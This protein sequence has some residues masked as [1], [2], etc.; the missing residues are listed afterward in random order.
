MHSSS[1]SRRPGAFSPS[2][3][4]LEAREVPAAIGALDPTF[5]TAGKLIQAGTAFQAAVF[6]FHPARERIE[7]APRARHHRF[8]MHRRADRNAR[9]AA[10]LTNGRNGRT[11]H[12]LCRLRSRDGR[13][14]RGGIHE[15]Q[16]R[17]N[18][19]LRRG[20]YQAGIAPGGLGQHAVQVGHRIAGADCTRARSQVLA[21]LRRQRQTREVILQR[22]RGC[23]S[24]P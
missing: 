19:S 1:R 16:A 7:F 12:R 21:L 6:L 17:I 10:L 9:L 18:R 8:A 20:R 11:L 5:G 24:L 14:L 23:R 3:E 22:L 15:T 4:A 2:L 13:R